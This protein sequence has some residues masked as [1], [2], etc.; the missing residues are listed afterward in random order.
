MKLEKLTFHQNLPI[1][2]QK[3]WDF[4]ATPANL[5]EITPEDMGFEIL[6]N[7]ISRM[8]QGQIIEYRVSPFPMVKTGWVTEITHV[9]DFEYFVD[10]QRFG[11]YQFWHH[12]HKFAPIEG[13]IKMTDTIHYRL[14]LGIVG[15]AMNE[16]VVRKKLNS[17]FKHRFRILENKF[18]QMQLTYI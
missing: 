1:S 14:P 7:D 9:K 17:I 8:F 13:G 3:A 5:N 18:G 2:I 11:P 4:F 6:T 12:H 10:E 16:L 15:K